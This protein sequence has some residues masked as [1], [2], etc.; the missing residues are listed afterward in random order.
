[1]TCRETIWMFARLRGV[2][3][4]CIDDIVDELGSLLIFSKHMDKQVCQLRYLKQNMKYEHSF[5][6]HGWVR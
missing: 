1:M 2:P 3:E 6:I 5:D 4:K